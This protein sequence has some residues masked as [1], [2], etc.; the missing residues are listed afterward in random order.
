M[1]SDARE[2]PGDNIAWFVDRPTDEYLTPT[3]LDLFETYSNIPR[4]K[5]ADHI[6]NVRNESW[7]VYPYPCIGRFRFLDLGLVNFEEYGEVL[8]RLRGGQRLLD[9]G[10]CFG[11]EIRKLVADGAPAD[12]LYG[13]DLKKEFTELGYKLFEDRDR[14][15]A[16]FLAADIF[17]EDS[18]LST[19]KGTLDIVYTGSFFHLFNYSQQYAAS[20]AVAKLLSPKKGS[21]LLGRQVGAVTAEEAPHQFEPSKDRFHQSPESFKKMWADLGKELG[22]AFSVQASISELQ[23]DVQKFNDPGMGWV[24]FVVRRE[25]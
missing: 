9:L 17:E 4:E 1:S 22:V 21:M 24:K 6:V 12:N 2:K 3:V 19:L 8:D 10:C 5:I 11:Q 13:C 18:E 14:L 7:K 20:L 25:E 16:R 15:S 23:E